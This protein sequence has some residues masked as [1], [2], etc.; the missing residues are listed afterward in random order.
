MIVTRA[1]L[2]D[3]AGVEAEAVKAHAVA[4]EAAETLRIREDESAE[5]VGPGNVSVIQ[6]CIINPSDDVEVDNPAPL[7]QTPVVPII[8]ASKKAGFC[9]DP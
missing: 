9:P 1:L 2:L 3:G 7:E 8:P 6:A 4:A 5:K